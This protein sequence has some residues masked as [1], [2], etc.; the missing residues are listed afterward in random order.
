[1]LMN[2]GSGRRLSASALLLAKPLLYLIVY[3]CD[4]RVSAHLCMQADAVHG[5]GLDSLRRLCSGL[6]SVHKVNVLPNK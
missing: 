4:A 5:I 6:W 3:S 2:L 1:M